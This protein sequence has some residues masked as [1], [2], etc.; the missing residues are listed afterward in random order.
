MDQEGIVVAKGGD[1]RPM[2]IDY[3]SQNRIFNSIKVPT[4]ILVGL[5]IE[6]VLIKTCQFVASEMSRQL[7]RID[8]TYEETRSTWQRESIISKEQTISQDLFADLPLVKF[9]FHCSFDH[10]TWANRWRRE[11]KLVGPYGRRTQVSSVR[12]DRNEIWLECHR[13]KDIEG[14]GMKWWQ[15][16]DRTRIPTGIENDHTIGSKEIDSH[17]SSTRGDEIETR[18]PHPRFI[19]GLNLLR[20]LL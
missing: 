13:L 15:K 5:G 12:F 14:N 18:S 3:L 20:A 6:V 2:F 9:L 19:E 4:I 10:Q 1:R 17:S 16:R 8:D 7:F 11:M